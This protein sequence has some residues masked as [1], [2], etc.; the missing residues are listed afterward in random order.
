MPSTS[1]DFLNL[2]LSI[3]G[4]KIVTRTYQKKMNLYLYIPP[5]SAHPTGCIK[6]TIYGLIRLC[7]AQNTYRHDFLRLIQLLYRHHLINRGWNNVLIRK[8]ITKA[9]TTIEQRI[10][11]SAAP[12]TPPTATLDNENRLFIHVVYHPDNIPRKRIQELYQHHL[13]DLLR[14]ELGISRP[15]IAYSWPKNLGDLFTKTKL[16]QA[17][18]QTSSIIMGEYKDGLAPP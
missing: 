17:P 2:T 4:N 8:L 16:H 6:G 12:T 9:C 14:E 5:A 15:T 18:G 13:G 7:Y 10:Q 11:P 3:K 1:V